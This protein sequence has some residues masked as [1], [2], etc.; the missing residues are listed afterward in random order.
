MN[1]QKKRGTDMKPSI[2]REAAL[3]LLREYNQEPFHIQHALTVEGVMGWYAEDLGY[4]EDRAFWSMAGLLH[5]IDF[6]R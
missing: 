3:A 5:D 6:E 2:T 1:L 4:G